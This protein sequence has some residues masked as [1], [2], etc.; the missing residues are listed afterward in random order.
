MKAKERLDEVRQFLETLI[1]SYKERENWKTQSKHMDIGHIYSK[2]DKGG[3]G[4]KLKGLSESSDVAN[5]SEVDEE[6]ISVITS[7]A[8]NT[9]ESTTE[10]HDDSK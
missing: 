5:S 10:D 1:K 2:Y 8:S 7:E 9:E 4:K 6:N 3:P